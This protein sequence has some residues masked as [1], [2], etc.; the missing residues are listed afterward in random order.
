MKEENIWEEARAEQTED[1]DSVLLLSELCGPGF[2]HSEGNP[3]C[4]L[5]CDG[6][7]HRD[8]DVI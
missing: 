7:S 2:Q 5:I 3:R 1:T 6:D 4:V 8:L